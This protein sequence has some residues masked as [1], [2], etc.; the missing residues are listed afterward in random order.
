[1]GNHIYVDWMT[2]WDINDHTLIVIR[3]KN[4]KLSNSSIHSLPYC[5]SLDLLSFS[6]FFLKKN[7]LKSDNFGTIFFTKFLY[8]SLTGF[9]LFLVGNLPKKGGTRIHLIVAPT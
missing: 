5:G 8:M 9:Y 1:M 2:F 7:S 3:M 6:F 4:L